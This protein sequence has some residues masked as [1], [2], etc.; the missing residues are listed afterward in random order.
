MLINAVI[1]TFPEEK[2]ADGERALRALRDGS[3]TEPGCITFDVARGIDDA[4]VFFLYE[5]WRDQA[6]LDAHY[7]TEHFQTYGVNGVRV[8]AKERIGHRCRSLD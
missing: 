1:Y 4:N 5:I 8:L 2:T 3:R 6:A 7:L